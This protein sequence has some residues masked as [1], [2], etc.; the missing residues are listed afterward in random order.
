MFKKIIYSHDWIVT[1]ITILILT[2]G[3]ATIYSTTIYG[4]SQ[5][6]FERQIIFAIAGIFIYFIVSL[7]DYTYLK[8]KT[9]LVFLYICDTILLLLA[10]LVGH[11]VSG[12]VRWLNFGVLNLQ[13]SE[14]TKIILILCLSSFFSFSKYSD[15]E[16]FLRSLI[17][18]APLAFLVF[19]EPSLSSTIVLTLIW[20]SIF[21][22]AA[23]EQGK[24]IAIALAFLLAANIG[25]TFLMPQ[26]FFGTIQTL[27]IGILLISVIIYAILY[28]VSLVQLRTLVICIALG[29][30]FGFGMKDVLWTHILKPYQRERVTAYLSQNST[31]SNNPA[32]YQVDQ[33]KIA[34][35]SGELTGKGF[36]QGTQSVLNFLPD[37]NTDFI[38]ASFSEEFGLIGDTILLCL[39][40]ILYYRLIQT[41]DK[42]EDRFG[43]LLLIGI[44]AM[45]I[46]QTFLN[47][48]INLGMLPSTGIPM[49][50][51]SY[52]GSS[53]WVTFILLGLTQSIYRTTLR[54]S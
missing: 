14:I 36:A 23:S 52:G 4:D 18:F 45:L 49:P 38:F 37:H 12:A 30:V 16:S 44:I 29:L 8:Y 42:V 25:G 2:I 15:R 53:L 28:L 48:G 20:L 26:I 13:P 47:I 9:I 39:F 51:I 41:A 21:F 40:A 24:I 32:V 22:M 54:P 7:A 43:F 3:I 1:A 5:N 34:V 17:I 11:N 35:G 50:L 31:N 19:I 6:T 46:V 10:F 27:S 33:S